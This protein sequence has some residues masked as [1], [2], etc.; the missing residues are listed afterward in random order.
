MIT[1]VKQDAHGKAKVEYQGKLLECLPHGVMILA[2]WTQPTKDLGYTHFDPGDRFIEYYYTDRWFNIFDI[3]SANGTRKGW[4]CNVAAPA[5]IRDDRIEQVD[6]IL[7]VWVNPQGEALILDEDEFASDATLNEEQ[8]DAAQQ[9]LRALLRLIS[10]RE[11]AF[12]SL[13]NAQ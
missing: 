5:V 3:A 10:A 11:E 8:R 9:G 7:D 2:H 1:V 12:A 13:A 6:L 4:Y